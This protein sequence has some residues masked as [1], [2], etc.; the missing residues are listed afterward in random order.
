VVPGSAGAA[1]S[2]SA[3]IS[4]RVVPSSRSTS[5]RSMLAR[6][7]VLINARP[8]PTYGM[9]GRVRR[10]HAR[11][12]A[13]ISS[14]AIPAPTAYPSHSALPSPCAATKPLARHTSTAST[15]PVRISAPVSRGGAACPCGG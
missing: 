1:L 8:S 11:T 5:L 7:I 15:W 2:I 9:N 6:P 14:G 3:L 4:P 10:D 12:I 13:A